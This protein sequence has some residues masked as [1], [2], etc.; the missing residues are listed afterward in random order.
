M[1]VFLIVTAAWI[2]FSGLAGLLI[3]RC[4]HVAG[5]EELER[6]LATDGASGPAAEEQPV[7]ADADVSPVSAADDRL[8]VHCPERRFAASR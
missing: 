8:Y 4:I 1:N 6:P 3:G 5:G 7:S 2:A